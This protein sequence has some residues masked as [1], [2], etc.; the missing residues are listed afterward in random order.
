MSKALVLLNMIEGYDYLMEIDL[1]VDSDL[2]TSILQKAAMK[3]KR[4][5]K[6]KFYFDSEDE[7]KRASELIDGKM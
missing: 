6:S 4:V 5:G 7:K 3:F 1:S 2:I